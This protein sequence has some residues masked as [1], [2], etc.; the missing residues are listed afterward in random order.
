[1]V[2]DRR[3]ALALR[4]CNGVSAFCSIKDGDDVVA[5]VFD[6]R[7]LTGIVA[8]DPG[9]ED[10]GASDQ[11]ERARV[12][13]TLRR[14][15]RKPGKDEQVVGMTGMEGGLEELVGL[16]VQGLGLI[17]PLLNGAQIGQVRLVTAAP[18]RPG[19]AARDRCSSASASS[20]RPVR[21]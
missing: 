12:V 20:S 2:H 1:M 16:A 7:G 14:C 4:F 13:P 21:K 17:K 3:G 15:F 8:I 19:L 9:R 11:G 10:V 18:I 5:D 6:R